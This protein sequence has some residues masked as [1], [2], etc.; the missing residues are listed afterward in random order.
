MDCL[1]K[2]MAVCKEDR[3]CGVDWSL[4]KDVIE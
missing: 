2:V 3:C 4:T 1:V